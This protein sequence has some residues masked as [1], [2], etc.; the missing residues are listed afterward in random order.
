M[1]AYLF[2]LIS[3]A[4]EFVDPYQR[5]HLALVTAC[6]SLV[7]TALNL[8]VRHAFQTRIGV[9]LAVFTGWVIFEVP[10]SSWRGGSFHALTDS[11]LKSYLTY[12]IV[13]S[14]ISSF[15]QLRKALTCVALGTSIIVFLSF[16]M[17][18]SAEG[19]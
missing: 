7:C 17:G 10:F 14:L 13:A 12:V 4:S 6:L 15:S 11:W 1:Q 5:F 2:L 3:R 8:A 19:R 16:R 9:A 18:I